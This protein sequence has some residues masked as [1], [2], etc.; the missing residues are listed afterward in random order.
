MA[1]LVDRLLE[2]T[3]PK[4]IADA[5]TK[6]AEEAIDQID[7]SLPRALEGDPS[8]VR[9][10]VDAYCALSERALEAV[11]AGGKSPQ[12]NIPWM[13]SMLAGEA[14]SAPFSQWVGSFG[15]GRGTAVAI[16]ALLREA[17]PGTRPLP[18]PTRRRLPTWNIEDTDVVRFY[19]AVSES[20][21]GGEAPL[22]RVRSVLGLSRTDLAGLFGVKRQALE[23][24]DT[25]GV[26][27]ERQEKLATLCA[28]V[29]LLTAQLKG[30]RIPGV[31]RRTA[32]AYGNRS[33]LEAIAAGDEEAVLDEL[34]TA[35]DWASAA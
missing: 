21:E 5:M 4:Q 31:V 19:R 13:R 14:M 12:A 17:L 23:R 10:Y 34:R 28:I 30:D 7:R 15:A 26:P 25:H 18:V 6:I 29:D 2:A 1:T 32:L 8:Q 9:L 24:W 16:V 3:P 22:E 27:A 11:E 33:I 20:L 35:F